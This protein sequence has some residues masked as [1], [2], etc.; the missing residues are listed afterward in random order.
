MSPAK[1]EVATCRIALINPNTSTKATALMLSSARLGLPPQVQ[2]EG[3]TARQGT[4]LIT[5][6]T[7]L[8]EAATLVADYGVEVAAEGFDAL[9]ISGFGDPGLEA[10]R[11]RV[12]IPVFG[13]AQAGISEA[14]HGGRRY[15]IVTVTPDLLASLEQ[16]A[17]THG[18]DGTLVSI[19]FTDGPLAAVM[20]TP[21]DLEVAL[22][23][24]CETAMN[25]DLAQAIVIGGG[26]L[27]QAA[28]AIAE[29]LHIPVIDPVVSAMRLAI[30][31]LSS[32][33]G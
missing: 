8:D 32:R 3:R 4:V 19:R 26:P 10:L 6:Q 31:A 25:V 20:S 30:K 22:L 7:A 13:I 21:Q 29:R 1:H 16:A 5:N 12:N 2:V 18:Q 33:Q 28:Q 17:K 15:A 14:A 23:S 11:Q 27:A 24:A 9:I